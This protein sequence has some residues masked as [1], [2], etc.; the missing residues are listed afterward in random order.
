MH[1]TYRLWHFP[2]LT[3]INI[4]SDTQAEPRKLSLLT[5]Y[6]DLWQEGKPAPGQNPPVISLP[7]VIFRRIGVRAE[8]PE[9]CAIQHKAGQDGTTKPSPPTVNVCIPYQ[10]SQTFISI[11]S[12]N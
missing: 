10:V 4:H 3:D 8:N 6:I 7:V 12:K 2:S 11:L 5:L 9:P 1:G